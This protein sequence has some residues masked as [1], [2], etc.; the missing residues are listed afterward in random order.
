MKI[1]VFGGSF[2]P[3]HIGHAMLAAN[4]SAREIV[5]E[6][7]IVISPQNPLKKDDARASDSDRMAMAGI[8]ASQCPR[9]KVC[10]IE[11]ELEPPYYTYRTLQELHRR[12]PEH[13]FRLIIGSDNWLIFDRWKE[14]EAIIREFGVIVYQRPGSEIS[15]EGLPE[16]VMLL[17]DTPQVLLS[18]SLIR[19]YLKSGVA[20]DFM[21]PT[22]VT[23]YIMIHGLYDAWHQFRCGALKDEDGK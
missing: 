19:D 20:V 2:D 8:V 12:Y 14:S 6:V 4:I 15:D 16:N 3:I 9:L 17:H 1:G 5:D 7:W 21:L 18:S 22:G 10:G 13:D 11:L 23:G